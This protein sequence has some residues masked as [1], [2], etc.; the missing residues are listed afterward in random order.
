MSIMSSRYQLGILGLGEG[1]S[2]MSAALNSEEWDLRQ[3][4]DVNETLCRQRC[5]EFGYDHYTLD[6][7]AMLADEAI[8]AI[9]IYTPDPLHGRHIRQALA[10][11][12][13][14]ICTKPLLSWLDEARAVYEAWA[15]SGLHV[16]V[17][18]ST[19]FFEPMIHQREDY[20][21]GRYG[22][23]HTIETA[24]N[25]DA[26]WFLDKGWSTRN[27]FSWLFNFL[28]HGA[29][30]IRWYMPD[31]D[32][33]MGFGRVAGHA[34]DR[35]LHAPN[36]MHFVMRARSGMIARC[37]GSYVAPALPYDFHPQISCTLRGDTGS[38]C[39]EYS[40][41][42]YTATFDEAEIH[43]YDELEPY[44][45]RFEGRSHHAGEYQNYFDYFARCL[46]DGTTPRPDLIEGLGTIALLQAMDLSMRE[47]RPVRL[48]DVIDAYGLGD[49]LG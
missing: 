33:V 31:V 35:D 11:G 30:L 14:V 2:A 6:Y 7:E 23:L 40:N 36:T 46:R 18:Q 48:Y 39:A 9:A 44:Y 19:R 10:A 37:S 28:S 12:K 29:D 13:H 3:V 45:F 25:S 17:G 4:C 21:A 41:L 49:I 43:Q 27:G 16:F 1:R 15:G 47:G 32:E 20:E 26:R 8:D 24:Y 22:A 42:R 5:A 38:G 34:A